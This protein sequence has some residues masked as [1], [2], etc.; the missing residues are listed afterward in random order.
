MDDKRKVI[1]LGSEHIGKGDETLGYAIMMTF[2]ET[3][4]KR[5]DR[6]K[7][8]I[9]WNTAVKL[10]VE[11]SPAV[12]RLKALEEKGVELL[13]GRLCLTD[14]CIADTVVVGKAVSMDE[15]LDVILHNETIS[16]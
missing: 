4:I 3:L 15:I 14:L 12:P 11:G 9:F 2:L 5:E 8:I 7:A 16:L 1:I 13:A 10:L 6:P